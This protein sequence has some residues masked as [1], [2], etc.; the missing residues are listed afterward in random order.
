MKPVEKKASVGKKIKVANTSSERRVIIEELLRPKPVKGEIK[1]SWTIDETEFDP[2]AWVV[3]LTPEGYLYQEPVPRY[4]SVENFTRVLCTI[5]DL[6]TG[7]QLKSLST[8]YRVVG[9]GVLAITDFDGNRRENLFAW[10]WVDRPKKVGGNMVFLKE[11]GVA[12]TKK[13]C[14]RYCEWLIGELD[15][16]DKVDV[17]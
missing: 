5:P 12:F 13:E 3:V 14:G 1:P 15:K 8:D 4:M 10:H 16:E 11:Q 6:E 17:K 7:I 2:K 9:K